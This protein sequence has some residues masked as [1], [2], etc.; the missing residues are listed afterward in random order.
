MSSTDPARLIRLRRLFAATDFGH[1]QFL[2]DIA[3]VWDD[4]RRDRAGRVPDGY[5]DHRAQKIGINPALDDS[6]ALAALVLAH[7]QFALTHAQARA[8]REIATRLNDL[9]GI[10]RGFAQSY[11]SRAKADMEAFGQRVARRLAE[12][13]QR[14]IARAGAP[15][16]VEP[17]AAEFPDSALPDEHPDRLDRLAAA[18][19][20]S[21]VRELYEQ[22]SR[23][24]PAVAARKAALLNPPAA[25]RRKP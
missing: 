13:T 15:G 21:G 2:A 25:P 1:V 19:V 6:A 11:V 9:P 4:S 24:Y 7:G 8:D 16:I 17:K 23:K 14:A 18:A 3:V 20:E 22:A 5:Y 12:R 10:A